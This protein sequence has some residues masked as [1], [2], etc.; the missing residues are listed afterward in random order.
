MAELESY[1][2]LAEQAMDQANKLYGDLGWNVIDSQGNF[3]VSTKPTDIS[4]DALKVEYFF[5][6]NPVAVC[7]YIFDHYIELHASNDVVE[8]YREVK[9]YGPD[10]FGAHMRLKGNA[11]VTP[12][13]VT[14][15]ICYLQLSENTAAFVATSVDF[16]G[17][18]VGED[19]IKANL[20]FALFLFEPVAGDLNKSHFIHIARVDPKGA[21]PASLAN[22]RLRYRGSMIRDMIDVVVRSL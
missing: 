6:K 7:R 20:D 12:R 2:P 21:I 3:T 9:R 18:T 4:I 19:S 5:D 11:V 22:S 15:F 14:P 1:L 17:V 13:E 16:P 8:F 10:A